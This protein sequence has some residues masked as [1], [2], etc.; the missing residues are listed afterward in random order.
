[1]A[2][3]GIF[4]NEL[5]TLKVGFLVTVGFSAVKSS[6]FERAKVGGGLVGIKDLLLFLFL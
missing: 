4:S 1:M 5:E 6:D 2:S 3:S